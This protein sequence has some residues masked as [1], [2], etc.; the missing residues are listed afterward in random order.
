M[1]AL[2]VSPSSQPATESQVLDVK[3]AEGVTIAPSSLL[4]WSVAES[5]GTTAAAFRLRD[6]Q[7]SS[8]PRLTAEVALTAGETNREWFGD[9]T[10]EIASGSIYLEIVSG[11]LEI[12]VYA[13]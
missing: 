1:P 2:P 9:Q 11:S 4:G 12:V 13:G 3:T 8:A 6:G 10:V 7:S 5:T